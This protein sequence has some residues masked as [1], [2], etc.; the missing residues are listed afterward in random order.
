MNRLAFEDDQSDP[1]P[2]PF[3]MIGEMRIRRRSGKFPQCSKMWLKN[4]SIS[5]LHI[6]DLKWTEEPWELS[7]T[8]MTCLKRS[9]KLRIQTLTPL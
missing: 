7:R 8:R 4:K 6:A 3:F 1:A 5:K 2:C 9:V